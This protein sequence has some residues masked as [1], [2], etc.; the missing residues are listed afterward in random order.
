LQPGEDK[1]RGIWK[2]TNG[3]IQLSYGEEIELG[4]ANYALIEI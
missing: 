2:D 1:F 3:R 4:S